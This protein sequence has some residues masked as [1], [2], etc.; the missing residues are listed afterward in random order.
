MQG[1]AR[2]KDERSPNFAERKARAKARIIFR[3]FSFDKIGSPIRR[4]R[5]SLRD[6]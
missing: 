5:R 2:L 1:S 6:P 3:F 4:L